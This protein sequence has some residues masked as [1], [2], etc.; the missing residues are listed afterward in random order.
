MRTADA[1]GGCGRRMRTADADGGCGRRMRTAN[2]LIWKMW[3]NK[4]F[5]MY[6]II[7]KKKRNSASRI[8]RPHPPS[9]SAVRI[10]R[11]HPPPASTVR[12]RRPHPP[13]AS[14]VRIFRA[15][16]RGWQPPG[17]EGVATPPRDSNAHPCAAYHETNMQVR[18]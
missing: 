11:P 17:G 3:T 2:N 4:H 18:C 5:F 14:A 15:G 1:D 6:S 8:H 12:I 10:R 7:H 13:S 16:V 9:A